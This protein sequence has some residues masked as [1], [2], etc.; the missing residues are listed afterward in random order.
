MAVDKLDDI[1]SRQVALEQLV[2]AQL[3]EIR[4]A[5]FPEEQAGVAQDLGP[6]E[7]MRQIYRRGDASLVGTTS[8][9]AAPA[10]D[11]T[12]TAKN[13]DG[14]TIGEL[15][16]GKKPKRQGD[17]GPDKLAAMLYKNKR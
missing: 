3:A 16:I 2:L 12:Q 6:M 17:S 5:V 10:T 11:I 7:A 9:L 4:H 1:E 13:P 15:E 14:A 8:P